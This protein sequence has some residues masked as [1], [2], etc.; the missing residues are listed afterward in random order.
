MSSRRDLLQIGA[1]VAAAS[2]SAQDHSHDAKDTAPSPKTAR[3][4]KPAEMSLLAVIVEHILPRTATP[5]AADAN[6]HYYIDWQ[7]HTSAQRGAQI[8]KDLSWIARQKFAKASHAEQ[9]RLLTGWSKASGEPARI[10]QSFKDLTIDGY[11]GTR[12]GLQME[13]GWNANTFLREFKGCTHKE[14]A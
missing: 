5:G 8:R 3:F 11:Y 13:L 7:C 9:V 2:V 1:A 4:F 12:E 10:F 6:V 14:H